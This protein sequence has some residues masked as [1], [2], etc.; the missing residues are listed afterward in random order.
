MTNPI[1]VTIFD[2][3]T[4]NHNHS[5]PAAIGNAVRRAKTNKKKKKKKKKKEGNMQG[6]EAEQDS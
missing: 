5:T 2:L 1:R 4:S 6:D 3:S